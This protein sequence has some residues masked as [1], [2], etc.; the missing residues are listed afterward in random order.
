MNEEMTR[1]AEAAKEMAELLKIRGVCRIGCAADGVPL[2]QLTRELWE[3]MFP[4]K[5]PRQEGLRFG[6]YVDGVFFYYFD[7]RA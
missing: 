7:V 1:L 2:A 4:G 5:E 3:R 6:V